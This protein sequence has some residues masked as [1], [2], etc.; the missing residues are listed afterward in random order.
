MR[1]DTFV[2]AI[3]AALIFVL[4]LADTEAIAQPA[5]AGGYPSSPAIGILGNNSNL[6]QLNLDLPYMPLGKHKSSCPTCSQ[7]GVGSGGVGG[8]SDGVFG[9]GFY[10]PASQSGP[11]WLKQYKAWLSSQAACTPPKHLVQLG[12]YYYCIDT[13]KGPPNANEG[14]GG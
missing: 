13:H 10:P 4:C 6:P 11:L 1:F 2:R 5:S 8:G 14:E 3:W 12:T 9:G 7:I